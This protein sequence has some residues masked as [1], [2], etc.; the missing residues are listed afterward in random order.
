MNSEEFYKAI[1]GDYLNTLNRL[2]NEQIVSHFIKEFKNDNLRTSY[3]NHNIENAFL[4][5]HTLKGICANLGFTELE[6]KASTLTEILR[7]RT[8]EN[9]EEA[10]K[11]VVITYNKIFE[12][13][14]HKPSF[15][16]LI[17]R[18]L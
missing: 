13:L 14:K 4:A 2:G 15:N 3:E 5:V 8:F 12:F 7:K 17:S 11:E 6:K 1:N 16:D 18:K 9:S 10:Y